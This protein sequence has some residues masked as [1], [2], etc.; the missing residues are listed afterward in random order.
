MCTIV[1]LDIYSKYVINKESFKCFYQSI[2]LITKT[3]FKIKLY[4]SPSGFETSW[5]L[6]CNVIKEAG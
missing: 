1:R 2:F 3:K 5:V 6:S 4:Y